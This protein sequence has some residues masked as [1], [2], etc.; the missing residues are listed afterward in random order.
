MV[1]LKRTYE[2]TAMT[3]E[4]LLMPFTPGA[5]IERLSHIR[6]TL[7]THSDIAAALPE[8]TP[9]HIDS[10]REAL[11]LAVESGDQSA[12]QRALRAAQKY[13]CQLYETL[14]QPEVFPAERMAAHFAE[15]GLP[16]PQQEDLRPIDVSTVLV[17]FSKPQRQIFTTIAF[18]H[19]PGAIGYRLRE[20]I[21]VAGE[22]F[23]DD[24]IEGP[25]PVF[26][27]VRLPIG[28]HR[29]RVES[30]NHSHFVLSDEFIV[31]VPEDV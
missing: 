27:R 28:E 29:L 6:G 5:A 16:N 18:E 24:T 15:L 10:A 12:R 21:V 26:R 8:A 3:E 20:T 25:L 7:A 30:R 1:K 31:N 22:D 19:S 11:L 13:L 17:T 2:D 4:P 9:A 14:R 23:V